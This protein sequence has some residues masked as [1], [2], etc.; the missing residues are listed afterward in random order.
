MVTI[1]FHPV[2]WH[3]PVLAFI[4]FPVTHGDNMVVINIIASGVLACHEDPWRTMS[5]TWRSVTQRDF[6]GTDYFL[7]WKKLVIC[8]KSVAERDAAERSVT[9]RDGLEGA[10]MEVYW[11][12]FLGHGP[13]YLIVL[14]S[15]QLFFGVL[16]HK[17]LFGNVWGMVWLGLFPMKFVMKSSSP[18]TYIFI[19]NCFPI[20]RADFVGI[21]PDF[22]GYAMV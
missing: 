3:S 8:R 21:G 6:S 20:T 10:W 11:D 19:L 7:P 9:E 12:L 18:N 5:K 17:Y 22:H 13:W 16:T 15:E 1:L 14:S 2:M 4:Q